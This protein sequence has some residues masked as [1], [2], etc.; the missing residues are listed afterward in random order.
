MSAREKAKKTARTAQ[1]S[2]S[3]EAALLYWVV[4]I[5]VFFVTYF[6]IYPHINEI[7]PINQMATGIAVGLLAGAV[8]ALLYYRVAK[9]VISRAEFENNEN[10]KRLKAVY[11]AEK[12]AQMAKKREQGTKK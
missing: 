4:A 12:Q 7:I 8:V 1:R 11:E 5:A 2:A 10:I 9:R 3:N 6:I